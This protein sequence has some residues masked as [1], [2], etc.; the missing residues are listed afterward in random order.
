MCCSRI[1]E[2]K[3]T[4]AVAHIP[5]ESKRSSRA[6]QVFIVSNYSF[7]LFP[8]KR[9]PDH[10]LL[11][12]NATHMTLCL[13]DLWP[14]LKD[15]KIFPTLYS[16][17]KKNFPNKKI[18]FTTKKVC[19]SL[20]CLRALINVYAIYNALWRYKYHKLQEC[21]VCNQPLDSS[22]NGRKVRTLGAKREK[23]TYN[24]YLIGWCWLAKNKIYNINFQFSV[25]KW[26]FSSASLPLLKA[27]HGATTTL[28]FTRCYQVQ[29]TF[30][31]VYRVRPSRPLLS[32]I[33]FPAS[34]KF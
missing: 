3:R 1:E 17:L 2:W 19:P 24:W 22:L 21:A 14:L 28:S 27:E 10:Y 9:I 15:N 6:N 23:E 11:V 18:P 16:T 20:K 26:L 7:Q 30:D 25:I 5:R 34:Q 12:F 13:H 4:N 33:A 8:I 32:T 31:P 29:L